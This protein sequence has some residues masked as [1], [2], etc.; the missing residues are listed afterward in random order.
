MRYLYLLIFLCI[1][2][3]AMAQQEPV[4]SHYMFNSLS[5][6][7]AYAGNKDMLSLQTAYRIQW[8]GI[9]GAPRTLLLNADMPIKNNKMALGIDAYQDRVGDFSVTKFYT[10]YAYKIQ[11]NST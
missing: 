8:L 2:M 9:E 10:S 1:R 11:L 4:F 5:F 7:P 6:N 3:L